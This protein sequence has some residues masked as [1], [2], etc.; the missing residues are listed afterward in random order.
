METFSA[1]LGLCHRW[2]PLTKVSDAELWCFLCLNK[3][4]RKQSWCWWFKTP[5]CPLW[6]NCNELFF[7]TTQRHCPPDNDTVP[8]WWW[9]NTGSGWR[10]RLTSHHLNHYWSGLYSIPGKTKHAYHQKHIVIFKLIS[11]IDIFTISFIAVQTILKLGLVRN[12]YHRGALWKIS[13]CISQIWIYRY[14]DS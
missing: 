7:P 3:R 14:I 2:I 10:R 12:W 5:S 8:F 9:I 4:L 1:L 6:R 11:R 13:T